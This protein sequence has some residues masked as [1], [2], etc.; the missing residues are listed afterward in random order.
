MQVLPD[1]SLAGHPEVFVVGDLA[2]TTGKDGRQLPGVAPTAMQG[3]ATAGRNVL[4]AIAGEPTAAF[5]YHDRGNMATIGRNYAIADF[6]GGRQLSGF[7]AWAAWLLIH[8]LNLIGF[9]NRAVVMT[10]W[11]WSYLT[12]QRGARLI[13]DGAAADV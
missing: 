4:R 9:R 7:L 12:Y 2:A 5:V 11:I 8:I 3:G 10:Q 1:L 13:T 6:G